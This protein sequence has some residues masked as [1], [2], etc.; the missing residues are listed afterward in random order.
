MK[1][2]VSKYTNWE[3]KSKLKELFISIWTD[4]LEQGRIQRWIERIVRHIE[5]VLELDGGNLYRE[6]AENKARRHNF[7][8]EIAA[9]VD[10]SSCSEAEKFAAFL[11]DM[12]DWE[13]SQGKST[14][15][16]ES[17]EP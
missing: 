10:T 3:N 14:D 8:D 5:K 6:G 13:H 4:R 11:R 2:V 17:S 1:R 9:K 7:D 15:S 12:S 16:E